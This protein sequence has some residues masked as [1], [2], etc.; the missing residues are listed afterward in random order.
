MV[1]IFNSNLLLFEFI[2]FIFCFLGFNYYVRI[3][4]IID[5]ELLKLFVSVVFYKYSNV[6]VD[7]LFFEVDSS[8]IML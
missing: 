2:D 8:I 1:Y 3:L 5:R 7:V 4:L 6:L